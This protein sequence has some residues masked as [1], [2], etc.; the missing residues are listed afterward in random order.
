MR[1]GKVEYLQIRVRLKPC[2]RKL[3]VA[4]HQ[5]QNILRNVGG[6]LRLIRRKA[7]RQP[8]HPRCEYKNG[9][10]VKYSKSLALFRQLL[11][12]QLL[13]VEANQFSIHQKH[14]P[15]PRKFFQLC[16]RLPCF[17]VNYLYVLEL[18]QH[19]YSARICSN[20]LK[21]IFI[22]LERHLGPERYPFV[23]TVVK[24]N[25]RHGI[26]IA[27]FLRNYILS[28]ILCLARLLIR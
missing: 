25:C 13:S 28:L 3:H 15:R 17:Y 14:V 2:L 20:D 12:L 21:M 26:A 7:L 22:V 10:Y 1:I 27:D 6:H 23:R 9:Y 11:D 8:L 16:A 5:L 19:N 18:F 4:R 24:K